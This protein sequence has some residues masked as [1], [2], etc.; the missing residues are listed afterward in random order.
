VTLNPRRRLAATALAACLGL[1]ALGRSV[2]APAAWRDDTAPTGRIQ[3]VGKPRRVG[4]GTWANVGL[5]AP[6]QP[7]GFLLAYG[8]YEGDELVVGKHAEDGSR[9]AVRRLGSL[10]YSGISNLRSLLPLGG[11][12]F[13]AAWDVDQ[14]YAGTVGSSVGVVHGSRVTTRSAADRYSP[15]L[16]SGDED[17]FIGFFA[18][19]SATYF[20][21]WDGQGHLLST[22]PL[23]S[24]GRPLQA[25]AF[26]DGVL[27][28][29]RDAAD[30]AWIEWFD[31]SGNLLEVAPG[32]GG[33]LASDGTEAVL[34]LAP[35]PDGRGLRVRSGPTPAQ[36]G[37]WSTVDHPAD[38]DAVG[39]GFEL[40]MAKGGTAVAAWSRYP[41]G[42]CGVWV[43]AILPGGIPGDAPTCAA[44]APISG[45]TAGASGGGRVWVAWSRRDDPIAERYSIWVRALGVD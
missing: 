16:G 28:A 32:A 23:P 11:N 6:R 25:L 30:K 34:E 5:I 39:Y 44:P 3:R 42:R 1:A 36:L 27:L 40:A 9:E 18:T 4:A 41:Q 19:R 12:S 22:R 15:A 31:A 29:L 35:T 45:L 37:A 10:G 33:R 13:A 24:T 14:H 20:A 21:R 8:R 7:D 26:R 2:P 17:G 38:A 43:R